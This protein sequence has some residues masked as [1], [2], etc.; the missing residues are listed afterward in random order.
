M[1]NRNLELRDPA[2]RVILSCPE[3]EEDLISDQSCQDLF[4]SELTRG[5]I[6]R[7][8]IDNGR[9]MIAIPIIREDSFMGTLLVL[10]HQDATASSAAGNPCQGL[11]KA[12]NTL[13]ALGLD[14]KSED[15][16]FY[17]DLADLIAK[18]YS[19]Q[20]EIISLSE[21]LASRYEELNLFYD[22]GGWLKG[23]QETDR[24]IQLII[25]KISD[26]LEVDHSFIVIPGKE[27][28]AI[29][30]RYEKWIPGHT[31]DEAGKRTCLMKLWEGLM[32]AFA[33]PLVTRRDEFIIWDQLHN[34]EVLKS[35]SSIPL[36]LI[37]V[38]ITMNGLR[39]GALGAFFSLEPCLLPAD[40]ELRQQ[41]PSNSGHRR[42]FTASDVRLLQSMAEVIS[43]LLSNT[44]LYQNLKTF[45]VTVVKCLVS[46]IE[47][48]DIYTR[49]HSER[50]NHI[51]M[52]IA[53]RMGLPQSVRENLN[54]A[55]ILHDIGKIGIPEKILTKP[56]KLSDGEYD[57]IK[58]H[59]ERG[60][61]ILKPIQ[62]FQAS[63]DGVRYHQERYD[64]RGYPNGL[65]GKE[66]PLS[67]RIIAVGDTYDAI[68][69]N[70]AYRLGRSH[71]EAMAEIKRVAGTQLDP[72]IVKVFVDMAESSQGDILKLD[73]DTGDDAGKDAGVPAGAGMDGEGHK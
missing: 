11:S 55:S 26:T 60:Y 8:T 59:P 22:V 36:N 25:D 38:P 46:A 14:E 43:I 53:D 67:A 27:V 68:T 2:G 29:S 4:H 69:S 35:C 3:P 30:G 12:R 28:F 50:V 63:L 37:A 41:Q 57:E 34:N 9:H 70:R 40:I 61:I 19:S 6:R 71:Q 47:A 65:K 66:I 64:G 32:K 7:L 73:A 45:L 13:K 33:D 21:E 58:K 72:D 23:V 17:L 31:S 42:A 20:M 5:K 52:L 10:E 62:G 16:K 51:S 24:S 54:W 39:Q 44:E 48:K 56:G 15:L 1:L 18:E 49:G